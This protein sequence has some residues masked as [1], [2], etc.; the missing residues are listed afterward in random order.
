MKWKWRKGRG[1]KGP[2]CVLCAKEG[3]GGGGGGGGYRWDS[4]PELERCCTKVLKVPPAVY[5]FLSSTKI[6]EEGGGT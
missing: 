2:T 1:S 6:G 3:G 4:G 5:C